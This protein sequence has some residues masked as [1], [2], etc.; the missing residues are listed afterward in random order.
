ML[1]IPSKLMVTLDVLS[2]TYNCVNMEIVV[3]G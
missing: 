3:F 2:T 1:H